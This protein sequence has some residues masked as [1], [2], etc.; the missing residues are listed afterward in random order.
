MKYRK[1]VQP[2]VFGEATRESGKEVR[3]GISGGEDESEDRHPER[4]YGRYRSLCAYKPRQ[5][6]VLCFFA[7]QTF[8]TL[9]EKVSMKE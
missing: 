7:F 3:Q 9:A 4:E 6:V 8:P 2:E 5:F 1:S